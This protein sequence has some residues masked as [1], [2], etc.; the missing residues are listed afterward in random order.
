MKEKIIALVAFDIVA[1]SLAVEDEEHQCF[2]VKNLLREEIL[3][4][5]STW[6]E[7]SKNRK[8][9]GVQLVVASSLGGEV[10]SDYV[11]EEGKSIT[12]YRN[13]NKS[14]LV[15]LE[16][17]DQSDSQGLQNFFTLRDS[18]FLDKSFD[19][20]AGEWDSVVK[21]IIDTSWKTI[22]PNKDVPGALLS[23]AYEVID[24]LHPDIEPI[25]ARKFV[26]F[27]SELASSWSAVKSVI[28]PDKANELVGESLYHLDLFPDSYWRKSDQDTRNYRRLELNVRYSDL[29]TTTGE[30]DADSLIKIAAKKLFLNLDGSEIELVRNQELRDLCVLYIK[31]QD[32][33]VRKK[34]QFFIFEQL[35][36]KDKVGIQLGDRVRQEIED[37]DSSRLEELDSINVVSGLNKKLTEDAQRFLSYVPSSDKVLLS[38]VISAKTRRMVERLASPKPKEFVNPIVESLRQ[39][40]LLK[41]QTDSSAI[42]ALKLEIT[43]N[44]DSIGPILGLFTFLYGSTLGSISKSSIDLDFE[45]QFQIDSCLTQISQPPKFT[46][47][48][49][50]EE[51]DDDD[52][53]GREDEDLWKSVTFKWSVV[54]SAGNLLAETDRMLWA[55]SSI[56]HL[57]FFWMLVV[58]ENSPVNQGVGGLVADDE[59]LSA[60]ESWID[61]YTSCVSPL[62]AI[63]LSEGFH[64]E[65]KH[66]L[67]DQFIAARYEFYNSA[68]V[69]GLSE[70][71]INTYA[72]VWERLIREARMSM[73]PEGS[74]IPVTDAILLSDS[75]A[76][77]SNRSQILPTHAF[78][79]RWISAYL[80]RS[81]EL[82]DS[83]L[84][85][86][87][88]FAVRDGE[89]YLDWLEARSPREMP[90]VIING[91]GELLFSQSEFSWYEFYS[92]IESKAAVFGDDPE[93]LSSVCSKINGYI[94]AHPY[95]KDG[96]SL[97]LVSPPSDNTPFQVID[98]LFKT[99]M[100]GGS[101][102]LT[103]AAPKKR[104]EG[105][106]RHIENSRNINQ[107]DSK[108][109]LFPSCDLNFIDYESESS[110]ESV[111]G[112]QVFD[113]GIVIDVLKTSMQPQEN[114]EPPHEQP[115]SFDIFSDSTTQMVFSG[116][117]GATSIEL[118][119]KNP[120][121]SLESWSTLVVRANRARPVASSQP[122]NRDF[123]ALRMN[124]SVHAPLFKDLHNCCHWVIT[125]ERHVS[126]R[127]VESMEAGAPDVLS[128]QDG[129]G[130]NSQ[131]TLVV[132]SSS[133]KKL[134][135]SRLVRKLKRLVQNGNKAVSIPESLDQISEAIYENTRLN[136]P[137]L[138]LKAMGISRVTE[139]ILGLAVAQNVADYLYPHPNEQGFTVWVSLDEFSHWFGGNSS[140]R[141]DLCRLTFS[142][143]VDG[144]VNLDVLILEGK[145]RQ[146]YDFH[147]IKQ[148]E[149]TVSFFNSILRDDEGDDAGKKIDAAYW[150]DQIFSA[151]DLCADQS[152]HGFD[153]LSSDESDQ[154]VMM[155]DRIRAEFR[156]GNFILRDVHSLYSAC[157]WDSDNKNPDIDDSGN[158][159]VVKTSREHILPLVKNEDLDIVFSDFDKSRGKAI[160][161]E[162]EVVLEAENDHPVEK[163]NK[164]KFDKTTPVSSERNKMTEDSLKA[165]YEDILHCFDSHGISVQAASEKDDPIIE[166]PASI[167]FKVSPQ[168]GVD[169]RK[170]YERADALK[171]KLKLDNEQSVG[172]GIDKGYVTIDVP[173]SEDQRYFVEAQDI[174]NQWVKHET[175]LV[176]PLGEDRYGKVV[177]INFSSSN[178]PHLL[179][180]G[181]TGSGKSEALNTILYGLV[182]LYDSSE[183]KLL[184]IDP[185]GTELNDFKRFDH[186]EGD[187]GWDD[188]DAIQ[189]LTN[190]VQEM[191]D[192]YSLF[193]SKGVRSIVDYNREATSEDVIPWW[194]IVLD[195]FADLTSDPQ[196]KKEIEHQLKRLAQKARACGIHIIIATQKPS[197]DVI[198]TNLRSNL[199]AQL[200]LRVKSGIES[201][202][203]MDESGAENLNGKGDAYLK[204]DGKLVR[205]QCAKVDTSV[206]V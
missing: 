171:L 75:V 14:G 2:R 187:I 94:D 162:V 103:V 17:E 38:D 23:K 119:P 175:D 92:Q 61:S 81:R 157:L 19:A 156:D 33:N 135:K 205:V 42:S 191:Q 105:I 65:G 31:N 104:W 146:V 45:C 22:A 72:D 206:L 96:F 196:A 21:L 70:E 201:R 174:F 180:G 69:Y 9:Q 140:I 133:G 95:K 89:S 93:V 39:Y 51:N 172:F 48:E 76:F 86:T 203:I 165:L 159:R 161:K 54:D 192:R 13:N 164:A 112:D 127:Q 179:I 83:A 188:D 181:T 154:K 202:V 41:Q 77:G 160:D 34:L 193:K 170:L 44:I 109:R 166:G 177:A 128:I 82:L 91:V 150:R 5:I 88:S 198:S 100:K 62:S 110:L 167:L 32:D 169:P 116:Q 130:S 71:C 29:R 98:R 16:T 68:K 114:T 1:N 10:D 87:V 47:D 115:G 27:A 176:S 142:Y 121:S 46:E 144:I 173:K 59:M 60:E 20:A 6:E 43:E 194:L 18:N 55:P 182:S 118:R 63:P 124:F 40:E 155:R 138:T 28:D 137:Q 67:S 58:D 185:K 3:H 149:E 120:D 85:G 168:S 117:D 8:L 50:E 90:P 30:V 145:L 80:R 84:N 73:V 163:I 152:R 183:L 197:G 113:V 136:S 189:L 74:R 131:A 79:L 12:W 151:V 199:P 52:D 66:S 97:L 64:R 147:G 132:S 37:G 204:S 126:R 125:L 78:R 139:E 24:Y 186:L 7:N 195:E 158:V 107:L 101:I 148:V 36:E 99:V 134:I 190:A 143:N 56:N 108:A 141:A 53:D 4:F 57:A 122:A 123:V 129:I 106:S 153:S 49:S 35:F 178:S 11:A 102:S 26:M 25:P 200:A 15:Y 111:I 184:L